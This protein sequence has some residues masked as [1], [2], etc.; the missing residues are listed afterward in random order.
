MR[1]LLKSMACS[2]AFW[3]NSPAGSI[4]LPGIF[5]DHFGLESLQDLVESVYNNPRMWP[6]FFEALS[7]VDVEES[8]MR[9]FMASLESAL[10]ISLEVSGIDVSRD[11][12]I[13]PATE[14]G[15]REA[16]RFLSQFFEM[17]RKS[18]SLRDA[19]IRAAVESDDSPARFT[20]VHA[21][22]PMPAFADDFQPRLITRKWSHT[23]NHHHD[24]WREN[25][26]GMRWT[27]ERVAPD[28]RT[29]SLAPSGMR[30]F[31][32]VVAGLA[33]A[34]LAMPSPDLLARLE[35]LFARTSTIHAPS[36]S[37]L[38]PNPFRDTT[39]SDSPSR[40]GE[41]AVS[42]PLLLEH[43]PGVTMSDITA[44]VPVEAEIK[45]S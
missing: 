44:G 6:V 24:T 23:L 5:I 7:M 11:L 28:E 39:E 33:D 40:V 9:D 13:E 2:K 14:E 19:F 4:Q 21:R 26:V 35:P 25:L 17:L 29:R 20:S 8:V 37:S 16:A 32:K 15:F 43:T 30:E 34:E 1:D 12:K 42:E 36:V 27:L 22:V 18:D 3:T 38:L 10:D 31:L 45:E 41:S